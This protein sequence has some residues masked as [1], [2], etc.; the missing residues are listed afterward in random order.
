MKLSIITINRNN[1]IGLDKT[2]A[3]I[4]R[5]L[6]AGIEYIVID[7]ASSDNSVDVIKKYSDHISYWISEKDS[8]I[9]NAMN[10]G[11]KQAKGEYI[12]FVNSG[13]VLLEKDNISNSVE[14]HIHG[15]D[16]IY[17]N[18]EI[19]NSETNESYVKSYP[20]TLDIKYFLEDTVPHTA[21]FIRRETFEKFGLYSEKMKICSDWAFF[22]KTICFE[23][24]SYKHVDNYFSR[25]YT[26]G[27]SSDK[28]N[29]KIVWDERRSFIKNELP[30]LYTLYDDWMI[31]KGELY[32]LK[33]ARSIRLIKRVG[34]L[35]WF[36]I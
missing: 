31:K 24:A 19:A 10:K 15:E 30:L 9:Y 8:G 29:Y 6:T 11:I 1:A 35:K 23:N 22:F 5:Q 18:L 4:Y 33:C 28:N 20:D 27:I 26:D 14:E 17:F 34:L 25:F 21:T 36:N 7:G 13:D 2:I 16:F 32:K 3:S 12:L